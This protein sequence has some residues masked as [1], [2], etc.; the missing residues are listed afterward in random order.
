MADLQDGRSESLSLDL[1]TRHGDSRRPLTLPCRSTSRCDRLTIIL[2]ASGMDARKGEDIS[3][4]PLCRQPGPQGDA[5]LRFSAIQNLQ[6]QAVKWEDWYLQ[7]PDRRGSGFQSVGGRLSGGR[8]RMRGLTRG[9]AES[10]CDVRAR[11]GLGNMICSC[12]SSALAPH[13]GAWSMVDSSEP[14]V[15]RTPAQCPA[16]RVRSMLHISDIAWPSAIPI[17]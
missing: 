16:R 7:F 11:R 17:A 9:L 8:R 12:R 3:G 5:H 14:L 4:L 1:Q 6:L 13:A 10:C 15:L 2:P